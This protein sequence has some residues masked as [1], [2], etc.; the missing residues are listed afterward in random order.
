MDCKVKKLDCSLLSGD[1]Q[2]LS[3]STGGLGVL[4]L[5]LKVPEV[6]KTSVLADLLHSLEIFSE[7]SINHVGVNLAVSSISDAPL[8]VQEPLW[9]SILCINNLV[10]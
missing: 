3:S 2:G 5:N 1:S 8:S 10:S 4:S 7:S 9:D 6:T